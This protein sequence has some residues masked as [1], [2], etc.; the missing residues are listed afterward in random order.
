MMSSD[1]VFWFDA[2]NAAEVFLQETLEEFLLSYEKNYQS[3]YTKMELHIALKQWG[4]KIQRKEEMYL[5]A[6]GNVSHEL[7]LTLQMWPWDFN[8]AF[9]AIMKR[10]VF[11]DR[12]YARLDDI[13]IT[14]SVSP[15]DSTTF[16][17]AAEISYIIDLVKRL[18]TMPHF[19][20]ITIINSDNVLKTYMRQYLPDNICYR[21][22]E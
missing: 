3:K 8:E 5:D 18:A 9:A 20:W 10:S 17:R 7:L 16:A 14:D 2:M 15:N 13:S 22:E 19:K 11:I 21:S 6:D 4:K 12:I 1:F